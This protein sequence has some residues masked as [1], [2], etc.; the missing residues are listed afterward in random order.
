M[1]SEREIFKDRH[2]F[3][4]R[5]IRNFAKDSP[6]A[7]R[8]VFDIIVTAIAQNIPWAHRL[9]FCKAILKRFEQ[10]KKEQRRTK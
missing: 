2:E 9:D 1:K 3:I 6:D 7:I 10:E 5:G 8:L 4:T